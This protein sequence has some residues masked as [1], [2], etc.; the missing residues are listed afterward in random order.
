M[1][2]YIVEET[3]EFLRQRAILAAMGGLGALLSVASVW[4]IL[5][6][7]DLVPQSE[8]WMA[9]PVWALGMAASF[10]FMRSRDS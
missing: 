3:D 7:F 1:G 8:G 4:G 5:A 2:R 6:E 9:V 10:F